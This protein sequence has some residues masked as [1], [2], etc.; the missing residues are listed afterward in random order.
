MKRGLF[1]LF[2]LIFSVHVVGAEEESKQRLKVG[3]VLG[4][5]GAKGAA[6]VGA[7]KII[8]ESGIPIDYIAGTSIGSIIGG[9]YSVGYRSTE[10]EQ[11]FRSQEWLSL[12]FDRHNEGEQELSKDNREKA[13]RRTPGALRGEKVLALLDSLLERPD[14]ISFDQLPIPFRCVA[15]DIKTQQEVVLDRGRLPLAIRASMAIPGAFKA[16]RMW[17]YLLVDGGMMNN[18]PVDV[19]RRMGADVVIAIDLTQHKRASRKFNLKENV[20]IGGLL[21]WV[22]SRPDR[23]KYNVNRREADVYINPDLRGFNA[24]SFKPENINDMIG[25]GETTALSLLSELKKLKSRIYT[26]VPY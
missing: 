14:S 17:D 23:E 5:G 16:V 6:E 2:L 8:E 3:L 24:A 1:I 19:V 22:V 13:L 9:L 20:G 12:L 4:G 10:I 7:L 11:L 21:D 25:I 26:K 18:L 15:T